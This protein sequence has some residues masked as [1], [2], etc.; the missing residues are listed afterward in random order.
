M[1]FTPKLRFFRRES[2]AHAQPDPADLGT[3]F[4]MEASLEGASSDYRSRPNYA[5][6]SKPQ[7]VAPEVS[8]LAWLS[9]R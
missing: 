7:H 6:E 4:G 5:L 2:T 8:P 3:C 1:R 9:H